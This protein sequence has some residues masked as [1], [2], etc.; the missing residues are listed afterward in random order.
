MAT[1]T[2]QR[3][4]AYLLRLW[5]AGTDDAPE[6]RFSVEDV[7]THER[8]GFMDLAGLMAFL[9]IQTCNHDRQQQ[10]ADECA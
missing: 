4:Y 8:H 3:Y 2:R 9:E 6:W 5:Q 10:S 7:R 1:L